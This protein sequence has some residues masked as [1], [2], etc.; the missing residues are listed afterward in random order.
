MDWKQPYTSTR[1]IV[2]RNWLRQTHGDAFADAYYR[3][4]DPDFTT[5]EIR[6]IGPPHA[7]E[8]KSQNDARRRASHTP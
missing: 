8:G 5:G 1:D 6:D 7:T 4:D 3:D 2:L